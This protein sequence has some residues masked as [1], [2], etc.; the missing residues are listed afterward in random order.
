MHLKK[1]KHAIWTGVTSLQL[2]KLIEAAATQKIHGLIHMVPDTSIS[3][4]DL[5]QLLNH[6]LLHDTI[7][8]HPYE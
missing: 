1:Q 8:I 7:I 2:G 4:Y 5:L 3:K 6:H